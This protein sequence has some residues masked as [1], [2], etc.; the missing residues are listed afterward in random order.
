MKRMII[1]AVAAAFLLGACSKAD[2][3]VSR[4]RVAV[5][6]TTD[7]NEAIYTGQHLLLVTC[8]QMFGRLI[9][10]MT[11]VV[12]DEIYFSQDCNH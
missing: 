4:L 5:R 11:M 1:L 12:R 7:L 8:S 6:Y 3:A 10:T 2:A 9:G